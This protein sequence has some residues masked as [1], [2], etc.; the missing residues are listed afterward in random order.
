MLKVENLSIGY[1]GTKVIDD[2]EL[3]I[4][5]GDLIT[6]IGVNGSGKSTLLKSLSRSLKP[7]NGVIY[8]DGKSIFKQDIKSVARKL[9]VLPQA[10]RVPEDFTVRDLVSYGR[11]PYLGLTGRMKKEDFEVID[12]SIAVTHIDYLQHRLLS[13]LSGGERQRTWLALALAQQPEVLLL[14]EPTTF[15]D[16]SCQFEVLEL[17][18]ALNAKL[19]ITIV[20]VLHDI[21]HAARYSK[22]ILALKDGK[23]Y[24][25]GSP[26]EIVTGKVLKDVFN[27]RVRVFKD[28]DNNCPYFIPLGGSCEFTAEL[29]SYRKD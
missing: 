13:T 15:L 27:I 26:D 9:S 1:G 22:R 20:M 6:I 14:D 10:P 7:L 2:M 5:K 21:N 3:F 25:M 23:V 19:G 28:H 29:D 24:R 16:I 12:W 18:G 11:Q 4:K 8:L 17:I